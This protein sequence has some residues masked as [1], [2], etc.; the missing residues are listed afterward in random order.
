VVT[1]VR[2]FDAWLS[3]GQGLKLGADFR[4]AD[5]EAAKKL[6]QFLVPA[7]PRKPLRILS[8]R[9]EWA[10][11][12]EELGRSLKSSRAE[13]GKWVTLQAKAGEE[14]V[15]EALKPASPR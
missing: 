5:A 9:P 13:D 4:C 10:A 7:E 3:F 11:V 6:E 2:D 15:R 14:T 1:K 12:A 8:G